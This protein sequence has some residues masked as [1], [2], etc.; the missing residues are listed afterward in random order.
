MTGSSPVRSANFEEHRGLTGPGCCIRCSPG[1]PKRSSFLGAWPRTL[2]RAGPGTR[3]TRSVAV[4][5]VLALNEPADALLRRV[6][7]DVDP[8]WTARV[9]TEA[10]ELDRHTNQVKQAVAVDAGDRHAAA[11]ARIEIEL[12]RVVR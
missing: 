9:H 4:R 10:G 7:Q 1:E 3:H 6:E 5:A 8:A 2:L 11:R 12:S